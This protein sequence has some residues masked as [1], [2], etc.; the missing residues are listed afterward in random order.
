ML[1]E[2]ALVAHPEPRSKQSRV[3]EHRI[4][5]AAASLGNERWLSDRARAQAEKQTIEYV[6][7]IV[8]RRIGR[9]GAAVRNVVI[10]SPGNVRIAALAETHL[11]AAKAR[12]G[13]PW[14]MI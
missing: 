6:Q 10:E 7:R 9:V 12:A 11:D 4:E 3:L 5:H 2:P 8:F 1:I 14:A 13:D